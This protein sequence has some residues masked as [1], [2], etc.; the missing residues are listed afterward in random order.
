M[1]DKVFEVKD[2]KDYYNLLLKE[3]YKEYC[4]PENHNSSLHA[5][6]C[7]ML[8][9]HLREWIWIT[10]A[11]MIKRYLLNLKVITTNQLEN[12]DFVKRKY[13]E[14][15]NNKC[16]EFRV[17][18]EICNRAKHLELEKGELSNI[19]SIEKRDGAFDGQ[20]FNGNF[21]ETN[22]LV[23]IDANNKT[24]LYKKVLDSVMRFW[25]G[26]VGEIGKKDDTI[27]PL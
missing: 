1:S 9:Y 27:I 19:S 8:S 3:Q 16:P 2:Y 17:I 14:W 18:R 5:I 7:A 24:V 20:F 15:I 26:F 13:Y 22:D 12:N 11:D 4:K 25:D 10:G 23:I 21:F 6:L